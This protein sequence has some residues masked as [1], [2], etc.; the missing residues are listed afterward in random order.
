MTIKENDVKFSSKL[1]IKSFELFCQLARYHR[2]LLFNT[3]IEEIQNNIYQTLGWEEKNHFQR[4]PSAKQER[5][6]SLSDQ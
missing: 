4:S 6:N 3:L 1:D 2:K 5:F